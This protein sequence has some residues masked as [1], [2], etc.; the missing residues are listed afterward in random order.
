[1]DTGFQ[2]LK[3]PRASLDLQENDVPWSQRPHPLES[4]NWL[5]YITVWWMDALIRKGA[6]APLTE[7]DVWPLAKADT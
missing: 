3:T 5:S 2:S 1:M 6:Q 7:R 4:V